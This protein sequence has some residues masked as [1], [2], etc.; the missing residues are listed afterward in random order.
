MVRAWIRVRCQKGL[1][2]NEV[3]A[4]KVWFKAGGV[5]YHCNRCEEEVYTCIYAAGDSN[6]RK[7]SNF[8]INSTKHSSHL[9]SMLTFRQHIKKQIKSSSLPICDPTETIQPW[10]PFFS[11]FFSLFLLSI[12]GLRFGPP[13]LGPNTSSGEM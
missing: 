8:F 7:D 2:S 1:R 11:V 10:G 9:F 4:I 6:D 3:L 13:I 5:V 12:L